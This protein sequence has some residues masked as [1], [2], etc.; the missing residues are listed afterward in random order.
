MSCW[1]KSLNPTYQALIFIPKLQVSLKTS[2]KHNPDQ[3]M[4][5]NNMMFPAL[6]KC[7]VW[8]ESM[9][10]TANNNIS[11]NSLGNDAGIGR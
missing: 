3:I 5:A 6:S 10:A 2:M 4:S 1:A 8:R 7:G 9:I 11:N